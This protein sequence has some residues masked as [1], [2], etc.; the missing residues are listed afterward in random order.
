MFYFKLVK[1]SMTGAG[2]LQLTL[3]KTPVRSRNIGVYKSLSFGFI[4]D[5][6]YIYIN[7]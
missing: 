1:I 6:S 2:Q 5:Q 3:M 7:I 4:C